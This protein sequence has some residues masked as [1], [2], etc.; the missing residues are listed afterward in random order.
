MSNMRGRTKNT[1]ALHKNFYWHDLVKDIYYYS[2][3]GE[4]LFNVL[5]KTQCRNGQNVPIKYDSGVE[6]YT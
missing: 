6:K 2:Q 4:V 3:K 1:R 5:C